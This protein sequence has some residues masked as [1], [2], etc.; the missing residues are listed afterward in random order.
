MKWCL[1][2]NLDFGTEIAMEESMKLQ[3][4]QFSMPQ[5]NVPLGDD[6]YC[7]RELRTRDSQMFLLC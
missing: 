2:V 3:V 7:G 6:I 5:G 4:F 1:T